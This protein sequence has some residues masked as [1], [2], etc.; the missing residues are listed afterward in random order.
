MGIVNVRECVEVSF[1]NGFF[2]ELP[3]CL[4]ETCGT[5]RQGRGNLVHFLT[6]K[7]FLEIIGAHLLAPELLSG[8]KVGR[9]SSVFPIEVVAF[10]G[11]EIEMLG[12]K[13]FR[14]VSSP[15]IESFEI[16]LKDRARWAA[17]AIASRRLCKRRLEMR[18]LVDI[19]LQE[20]HALA[21]QSVE[22]T[23]EKFAGE[24]IVERMMC[25]LRFLQDLA[26]QASDLGIG[27][28]FIKRLARSQ[29]K[30][31]DR[32]NQR[33]ADRNDRSKWFQEDFHIIKTLG[34]DV[35]MNL[36]PALLR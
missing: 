19:A 12:A 22:I 34:S 25:E 10:V 14:N 23:I 32:K 11:G 26:R 17:V 16:T 27:R 20:H 3:H 8:C 7:F 35:F 36:S 33:A 28:S 1:E 18:K 30:R 2:V 9:V 4:R 31:A 13:Q 29:R 15:L 6:S 21:V 24:L 5:S